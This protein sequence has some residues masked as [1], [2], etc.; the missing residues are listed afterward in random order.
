ML[1]GCSSSSTSSKNDKK[2]DDNTTSTS[3][4]VDTKDLIT[5]KGTMNVPED[6]KSSNLEG[7]TIE[8][9]VDKEGY[10]YTLNFH[11]V[12]GETPIDGDKTADANDGKVYYISESEIPNWKTEREK[13][14]KNF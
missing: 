6:F 9:T 3:E 7:T 5:V 12:S 14:E 8:Y 11:K 10:V 2:V 13:E 4:T 1:C